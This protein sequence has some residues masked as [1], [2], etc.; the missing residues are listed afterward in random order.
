MVAAQLRGAGLRAAAANTVPGE[1]EGT[2]DK[3]RGPQI[4]TGDD[5]YRDAFEELVSRFDL[6]LRRRYAE[7][8]PSRGIMIADEHTTGISR[9]LAVSAARRWHE[10]ARRLGSDQRARVLLVGPT[11][12]EDT[13]SLISRGHQRGLL[14]PQVATEHRLSR[15]QFLQ[16]TCRKAQLPPDAWRDPEIQ[17]LGFTCEIISEEANAA[18]A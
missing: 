10:V 4:R 1:I 16:E 18:H 9:A 14:L 11:A 17:S 13:A 3:D 12:A 8:A 15:E 6:Y 5:L 2:T 7:G